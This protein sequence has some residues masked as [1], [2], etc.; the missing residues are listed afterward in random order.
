MKKIIPFIILCASAPLANASTAYG[1]LGNF[2]TVNDTGQETHGFEIEIENVHSSSITYTY[3]YNHYGTPKISED[4]SDPLHPKTIIRYE[5]GKDANGNYTAYTA[6]PDPLNPIT[7]TNGHQ[8]TNPA[9]NQGC[10]HFGVGYYGTGLVHY[11]WLI[12]DGFGNLVKGQPVYVAT[13]TWTYY[14]PQPALNIPAKV[15]AEIKA[16]E[17]IEIPVKEFGEAKWVKE[18]RT[19][20]HNNKPVKLEDLVSDDPADPNDKNWRNNE[21]DEVEVEFELLQKEFA[22]PLNK[23]NGNK[24]KKERLENGDEV[25]TR[26]YESYKYAGPYDPETNEA[27]CDSWM[28]TWTQADI[29]NLPPE[30]KDAN[31]KP[32]PVLGDYIGAQMVEYKRVAPLGLIEHIQ[33]GDKFQPYP[34]RRV[35][36]GGNTPYI[37][38]IIAG[39][40]PSGLSINKLTGML[41][42][43]P[44][45][46]G[47]FNFT[48]SAED[49]NGVISTKPYT[50][51][52]VPPLKLKTNALIA[53]K[54]N[55]SYKFKLAAV[56]GY[57]PYEW[58][59]DS[60]PTG[61]S[62]SMSGLITGKPVAG[63]QGVYSPSFTVTDDKGKTSTK[64]LSLTINP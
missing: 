45:A 58:Q 31:G 37:T 36:V 17:P 55:T 13:P 20:T 62:M 7:P 10:E 22:N 8:C 49:K 51:K 30:C 16:P 18:I 38:K 40:L 41:S 23:R 21:P 25:V 29:D 6:V 4:N 24:A 57:K 53:G 32:L 63:T 43:T 39:A 33:N 5:S 50:V 44:K 47:I 60:L 11:N 12:D 61:L 26:R 59:V 15:Q 48:V 56:G 14:P 2:D 1:S 9:V 46:A 3:D 27:L 28:D 52:I 54:V 35:V 19:T 42:G 64:V 34:K